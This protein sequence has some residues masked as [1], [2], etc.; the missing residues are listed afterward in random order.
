V[1]VPVIGVL[2]SGAGSNLQ[3][4]LDAGLPVGAV[5]SNVH[6]AS[7][8][9]RAATASV[10]TGVFALEAYPSR[11]ARDVAMADWLEAHGVTLVVCAGYM[12]LLTPAFLERFPDRV[13]NVHPALLPAFPG[14]HPVRDAL[15]AGVSETGATVHLVDEGVDT[16]RALRRETVPV[17]PGDTV[18]TLHARIREVEHRILPEVVGELCDA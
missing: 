2:V 7:A 10:P 3:A 1:G 8:L 6:G 13:V 12:H 14:A 9:D 4:L 18:E 16:G 15:E 5:A 17:L 11:E